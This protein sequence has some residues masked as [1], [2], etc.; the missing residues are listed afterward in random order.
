MIEKQENVEITTYL[1]NELIRKTNRGKRGIV[2]VC[3]NLSIF[4]F[5]YYSTYL[6]ACF[7]VCLT[8]DHAN[9]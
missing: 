1:T 5:V 3:G 8:P 6:L 7:N 2:M 9:L 4:L